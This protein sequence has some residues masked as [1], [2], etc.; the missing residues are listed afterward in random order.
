LFTVVP[1][2]RVLVSQ[3]ALHG[4][5]C[6]SRWVFQRFRK[7][8]GLQRRQPT[9]TRVAAAAAAAAAVRIA[10]VAARSAVTETGGVATSGAATGGV[11]TGSATTG[12]NRTGGVLAA[13]LARVR[14]RARTHVL[15][16]AATAATTAA[17]IGRTARARAAMATAATTARTARA[18]VAAMAATATAATTARARAAMTAAAATTARPHATMAAA[19]A[20][21]IA[22][23]HVATGSPRTPF[24]AP[25]ESTRSGCR[26]MASRGRRTRGCPPCALRRRTER[27]RESHPWQLAAPSSG[28]LPS[29]PPP[30]ALAS[31]AAPLPS[32][33]P[34]A[35][36]RQPPRR[37][38]CVWIDL[39]R[40]APKHG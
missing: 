4:C 27:E 10:T 6:V 13:H 11:A 25:F 2:P 7:K 22:R 40:S 36:T 39:P 5:T 28:R 24:R 17:T 26:R 9:P 1:G 19:A 16:I 15:A 3:S 21:T 29:S 33:Q 32:W 30:A 38:V 8:R 31:S 23:D 14:S 18:R 20:A 37:C 35:P 12:G 34:A